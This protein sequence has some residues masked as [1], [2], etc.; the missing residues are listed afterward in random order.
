MTAVQTPEAASGS[1]PGVRL[2]IDS[3]DVTRGFGQV[4]LAVADV[5]RELLERQAIR[6]I[7]AGDLDDDQ[8]ERLGISLLRIRE[9]I[10]E[11]RTTLS[12]TGTDRMRRDNP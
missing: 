11:L 12:S 6:R 7:D 5:L 1:R 2:E 8:I 9:E 10:A 4:V 3:S